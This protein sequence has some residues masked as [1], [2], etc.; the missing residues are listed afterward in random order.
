MEK[1]VYIV[2]SDT[3]T[4][5]SKIIGMYTGKNKNHTSIAFDEELTEMYSFGRKQRYNPISGGFVEEDPRTGLFQNA[6]C[7][8][9]QYKVSLME[10]NRMRERV[11]AFKTEQEHYKYNLLGLF[12]IVLQLNIQR[13]YAFF[14]SEFVATILKESSIEIDRPSFVQPH[15]FAEYPSMQLIYDGRMSHF[16]PKETSNLI[17]KE[18]IL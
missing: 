16:L 14:C 7:S 10:Y 15:H 12:G 9:F 18:C 13:E 5:F 6:N 17:G 11:M 1:N 4:W 8:I 2:L 3:G